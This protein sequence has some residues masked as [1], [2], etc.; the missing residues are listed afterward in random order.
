MSCLTGFFGYLSRTGTTASLAEQLLLAPEAGAAAAFMP[1]GM[2]ATAGQHILNTALFD[3]IF[4]QDIRALGPAISAAKQNL[5]ANGGSGYAQVSET[6]LLLG[7]PAMQLKVP[8]PHKV[9][10]VEADYLAAGGVNLNWQLAE[11]CDGNPVAGYNL[12]RGTGINAAFDRVNS[13]LIPDPA[14]FDDRADYKTDTTYYYRVTSVDMDGDESVPS[15]IV[16]PASGVR[17][18]GSRIGEKVCFI[19]AVRFDPTLSLDN[20]NSVLII[21]LLGL[22]AAWIGLKIFRIRIKQNQDDTGPTAHQTSARTAAGQVGPVNLARPKT[23][24]ATKRAKALEK[25]KKS[26][27]YQLRTVKTLLVDDDEFIRGSLSL[28]FANK[29]C[30]LRAEETAEQG[31]KA[32]GEDQFDI[33]ISDFRLP[34]MNGL[35]F[36]KSATFTQPRA[37]SVLITAYRDHHI[38]TEAHSIGVHNFIEKPFSVG[39]LASSL[40]RSIQEKRE[41][42]MME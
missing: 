20:K 8:L 37:V 23:T 15:E 27:F 16:S 10:G 38:F 26:P 39:T 7:D 31:L 41:T 13:E 1:T 33:I 11:D 30:F 25:E 12:Y 40:A 3:A 36:L 5:L 29:G 18:A 6:F 24:R 28:A 32:L 2:T 34:G 21:I 9:Q 4:A 14:Y 42:G 17:G 22:C 35:Q 19:S